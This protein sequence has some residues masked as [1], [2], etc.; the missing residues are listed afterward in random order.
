MTDVLAEQAITSTAEDRS[1]EQR[2]PIRAPLPQDLQLGL[3]NA[4]NLK[5]TFCSEHY[6][7]FQPKPTRFGEP[8]F[9][10]MRRLLPELSEAAFHENSEFLVDPAFAEV[11]GL[12]TR[13]DV[14]LSLNTN[15][16][17]IPPSNL[18]LLRAHRAHLNIAI[19][20]D[21][22]RS[23][24]YWKVRG[25]DFE[26]V[27]ANARD[28]VDVVRNNPNH[29]PGVWCKTHTTA[30]FIIMRENKDEAVDFLHLAADLG[31]DRVS[32]YRL[33]E[34]G[35]WVTRR[36]EFTFDYDAQGPW[37][38]K[39]EYNALIK[40]LRREAEAMKL[41]YWLPEPYPEGGEQVAPPDPGYAPVA[42]PRPGIEPIC[43][44]PWTGRSVIK[45]D[46]QLHPCCHAWG[47]IGNVQSGDFDAAW[48]SERALALRAALL[49][50]R[51]PKM[52]RNGS[53]PVY[54]RAQLE[55]RAHPA[56]SDE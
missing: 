13:H 1:E 44:K 42:R 55:G 4:C 18:E 15:A 45:A 8:M 5:C 24:T 26:R 47:V 33:H 30:A 52:C 17:T 3:S 41:L 27:L 31:V 29:E 22:V 25:A 48:N 37:T 56:E 39:A 40:K 53:C 12:C 11:V 38:F 49:E 21:A 54:R 14:T 36:G 46:G 2:W 34:G 50:H 7:G 51:F 20:L 28:L 16:R 35:D 6:P 32:F 43:A 23:E 10:M 19:S 9:E